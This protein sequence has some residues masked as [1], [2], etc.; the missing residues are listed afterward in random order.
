M[1]REV[2]QVP[3]TKKARCIVLQSAH[4]VGLIFRSTEFQLKKIFVLSGFAFKSDK[5]LKNAK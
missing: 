4:V 1:I 3:N 2:L 5:Y